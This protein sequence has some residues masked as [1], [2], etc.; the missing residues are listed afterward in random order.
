MRSF[1]LLLAVPL[2]GCPASD[3]CTPGDHY[4]DR[5]FF[6]RPPSDPGPD[7]DTA[8]HAFGS[9]QGALDAAGGDVTATVC[10]AAGTYHEELTVPANTHLL[11]APGRVRLRP[12][13]ARR[14]ALPTSVDRVLLRL[15]SDGGSILV[16][17][18][19]V[20][21]AGLC[22]D[23]TGD[24]RATVQDSVIADCGVGLRARTA[25]VAL[26]NTPLTEHAVRGIDAIDSTVHVQAGSHLLRNGRPA[27][28]HARE[29]AA[30]P[31]EDAGWAEGLQPGRGAIAAQGSFFEVEQ[32]TI[33][34]SD[35]TAAV[36]ELDATGFIGSELTL[37]AQ[38]P[39][40]NVEGFLAGDAGGLGPL[41]AMKDS[42]LALYRVVG[43][44]EALGLAH[45]TG[46]GAGLALE[47]V[48][49]SG[50]L[51]ETSDGSA[52]AIVSGDGDGN[53]VV[54]HSSL[55]G[56]EAAWGFDLAGGPWGLEVTNSILWGQGSARGVRM[57][58]GAAPTLQT[59]LVEDPTLT[60][61]DLITGQDPGFV[62]AGEGLL[63]PTG[64]P[65]RCAGQDTA[66]TVDL[67][68]NPRPFS[69]GKA[70]DLGAIELQQ[71]CP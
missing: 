56:P 67:F 2:L 64:S 53:V 43:R 40:A 14:S 13:Q 38:R 10:V 21:G 46:T 47:N 58:D 6:V 34:E 12:P 8:A 29:E 36:V 5:L 70:P 3:F 11:A 60:G 66:S 54:L 19:D 35:Y 31:P 32:I 51:A 68:G 16:T 25:E 37:G 1:A 9:I 71:A 26:S 22:L 55:L 65:A 45:V 28:W 30:E 7:N 42:G 4:G 18:L 20:R 27:T 23:V 59:V 24:Q 57:P 49:W 62:D 44:T 39:A 52:G 63:I 17:G 33:D 15:E 69:E 50:R 48:S 61:D 41:F